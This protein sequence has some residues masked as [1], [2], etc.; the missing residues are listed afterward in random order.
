M[1]A[2][3]SIHPRDFVRLKKFIKDVVEYLLIGPDLTHV[4]LIEYS[5][6]ASLQLRFNELYDEDAIKAKIDAVPHTRGRTRM[7]LALEV[8]SRDL[9]TLRGGMRPSARKVSIVL[10]FSSKV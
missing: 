10:A 9:F 5:S 2:S 7:D 6:R 8:A 4:G 3:G 1:D